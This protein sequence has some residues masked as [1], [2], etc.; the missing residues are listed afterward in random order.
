MVLW[1]LTRWIGSVPEPL[2]ELVAVTG[3]AAGAWVTGWL[4]RHTARPDLPATHR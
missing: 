4:A 2:A 3:A 1:G